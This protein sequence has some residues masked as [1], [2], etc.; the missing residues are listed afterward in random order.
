MSYKVNLS[1]GVSFFCCNSH[2]L[3]LMIRQKRTLQAPNGTSTT[4]RKHCVIEQCRQGIG[5]LEKPCYKF[6][7][8][9]LVWQQLQWPALATGST[10]LVT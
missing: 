4:T 8:V 6:K 10:T 1:R 9:G 7:Y 3:L 5:A 2:L